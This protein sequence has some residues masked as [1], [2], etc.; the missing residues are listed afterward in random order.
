MNTLETLQKASR[1]TDDIEREAWLI[2][3]LEEL[4][5]EQRRWSQCEWENFIARRQMLKVFAADFEVKKRPT[6]KP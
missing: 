1:S 2:A 4:C 3:Y 5:G 6:I